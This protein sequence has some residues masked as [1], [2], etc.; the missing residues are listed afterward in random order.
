MCH[1]GRLAIGD[2]PDWPSLLG[3]CPARAGVMQ[4]VEPFLSWNSVALRAV[5]GLG[6]PSR[7]RVRPANRGSAVLGHGPSRAGVRG[8]LDRANRLTLGRVCS[9]VA[10][11]R[12]RKSGAQSAADAPLAQSAERLHGKEKVYGS[13]P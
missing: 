13:I 7:M 3:F 12:I 6:G 4:P 5:G 1:H 9:A 10:A 8:I 2:W 11:V